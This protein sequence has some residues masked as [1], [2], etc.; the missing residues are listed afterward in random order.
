[1]SLTKT[2]EGVKAACKKAMADKFRL[3]RAVGAVK[4]AL[5]A[6]EGETAKIAA[7]RVVAE[8]DDAQAE[9]DRIEDH[10]LAASII[11]E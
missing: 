3:I 4:K 11:K 7:E 6:Q 9:I 10:R 5:E 8:R 1:M 2:V